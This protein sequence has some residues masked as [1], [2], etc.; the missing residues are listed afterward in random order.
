MGFNYPI[1]IVASATLGQTLSYIHTIRNEK[2]KQ[3]L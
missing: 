3:S 2:E 1:N